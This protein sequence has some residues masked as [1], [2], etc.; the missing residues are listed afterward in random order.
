M[1]V[2]T[3]T[4]SEREYIEAKYPM[5]IAK[6]HKIWTNYGVELHDYNIVHLF[7]IVCDVSCQYHC[8]SWP[9]VRDCEWRV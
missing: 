5:V 4:Q 6:L 7:I 3:C 2:S 8:L 1:K 9:C